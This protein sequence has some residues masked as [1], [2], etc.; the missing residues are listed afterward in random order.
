MEASLAREMPTDAEAYTSR[1]GG[2]SSTNGRCE[3]AL[4][5]QC[6]GHRLSLALESLAKH[7]ELVGAEAGDGVGRP[8]DIADALGQL[9]EEIVAGAVAEAV[10]HV[11]EAVDV[12]EEHGKQPC[13]PAEPSDRAREAVDQQRTVGQVP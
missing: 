2:P 4:D 5:P 13:D 10:V 3:D 12:Y 7:H 8:K 11:L 1:P 6:Q 9:D